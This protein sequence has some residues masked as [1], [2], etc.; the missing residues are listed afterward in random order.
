MIVNVRKLVVLI[1]FLFF[2]SCGNDKTVSL[3]NAD[4]LI[5]TWKGVTKSNKVFYEKWQ[6]INDT[7]FTNFN[8]RIQDNDT[9]VGGRS[10]IFLSD[11]KIFYSNG[12]TD[13]ASVQWRAV[14]YNRTEM[15]FENGA[16]SKLQTIKFELTNDN[17]WNASIVVN[18]DTVTYSLERVN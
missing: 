4:W 14:K 9:I 13:S 10:K 3:N 2:L 7:L 5:G 6:Y 16:V 17:K 18:T 8:Y 1:T 15:V 11:N 12:L